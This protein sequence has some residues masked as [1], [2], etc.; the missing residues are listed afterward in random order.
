M[1]ADNTM[2]L[3]DVTVFSDT[4]QGGLAGK[5][6][7]VCTFHRAPFL[8]PFLHRSALSVSNLAQRVAET[9]CTSICRQNSVPIPSNS[10]VDG[11]CIDEP[12]DI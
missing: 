8:T 9:S 7:S 11:N 12:Q 2:H 6:G 3:T 5:L 4:T 1:S 10:L